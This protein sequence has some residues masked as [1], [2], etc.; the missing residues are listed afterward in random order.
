MKPEREY[1][2]QMARA[3]VAFYR[4]HYRTKDNEW[5]LEELHEWG[6]EIHVAAENAWK[7]K[8]LSKEDFQS[9]VAAA[10]E[11]WTIAALEI[12]EYE[13]QNDY[14]ARL[15]GEVSYND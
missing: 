1:I 2:D 14:L 13:E 9:I 7:Q 10:R 12:K 15:A 3:R 4:P 8:R 6:D 11:A 5:I